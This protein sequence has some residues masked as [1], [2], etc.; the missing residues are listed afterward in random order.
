MAHVI[1]KD[2]LFRANGAVLRTA[3]VGGMV[4]CALGS[5]L[6]DIGKWVGVW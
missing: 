1:E 4:G 6:Y 3:I 2:L 5:A